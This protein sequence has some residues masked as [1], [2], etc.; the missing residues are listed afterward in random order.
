[1]THFVKI[2]AVLLTSLLGVISV[3]KAAP[4]ERVWVVYKEGGKGAV[5]RVL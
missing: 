5:A 4:P 2:A 1:M 3:T